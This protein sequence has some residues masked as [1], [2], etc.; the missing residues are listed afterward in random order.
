MDDSMM[1]QIATHAADCW[2]EQRG[3]KLSKAKQIT[4]W[5]YQYDLILS[6]LVAY[7]DLM[8]AHRIRS[9]SHFSEN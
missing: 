5:R 8:A 1:D 2:L 7:R 3:G 9:Q 6:S 4:L